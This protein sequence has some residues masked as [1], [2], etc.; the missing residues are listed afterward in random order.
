M[1]IRIAKLLLGGLFAV[2]GTLLCAAIF[3]LNLNPFVLMFQTQFQVVNSSNETIRFT[4][5]GIVQGSGNLR[6]LPRYSWS[7]PAVP[8]VQLGAFRLAPGE[9][10]TIV[11]DWDD[12]IFTRILV[13]DADGEYRDPALFPPLQTT[14]LCQCPE[15]GSEVS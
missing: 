1:S 5:L 13:E 2:V 10:R 14:A 8:S 7:V 15:C 9:S 6:P 12:I 4:P 11:Y 3:L